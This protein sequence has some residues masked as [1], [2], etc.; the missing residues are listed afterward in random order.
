MLRQA[1]LAM[2]NRSLPI[3]EVYFGVCLGASQASCPVSKVCPDRP[4]H[5]HSLLCLPYL[6]TLRRHYRSTSSVRYRA[7]RCSQHISDPSAGRTTNL[8]R[9][10]TSPHLT[11]V[12]PYLRLAARLRIIETPK[13]RSNPASS[14]VKHSFAGGHITGF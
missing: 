5:C 3:P 10:L 8:E 6:H 1:Q 2:T 11:L 13:F 9:H 7:A 14:V 4:S 12:R